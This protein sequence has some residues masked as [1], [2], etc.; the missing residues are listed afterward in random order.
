MLHTKSICFKRSS[1]SGKPI[2]PSY[3]Q[4]TDYMAQH[5]YDRNGHCFDY[6]GEI[7]F[8]ISS[9]CTFENIGKFVIRSDTVEISFLLDT[10][11]CSRDLL[12]LECILL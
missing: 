5:W 8:K 9:A 2:V 12:R 11:S 6:H 1:S 3:K 4:S 10:T 7:I